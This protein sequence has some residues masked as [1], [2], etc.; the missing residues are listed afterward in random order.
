MKIST[1]RQTTVLRSCRIHGIGFIFYRS[2]VWCCGTRACVMIGLCMIH[3]LNQ[4]GFKYSLWL[5]RGVYKGSDWGGHHASV[6]AP[7]A[8]ALEELC[9]NS[10]P[11]QHSETCLMSWQVSLWFCGYGQTSYRC[12]LTWVKLCVCIKGKF[13]GWCAL[14]PQQMETDWAQSQST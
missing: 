2:C 1:L 12:Q 4:L 8:P 9:P 11:H 5:E 14:H 13:H 7:C 10:H 6:V 3:R